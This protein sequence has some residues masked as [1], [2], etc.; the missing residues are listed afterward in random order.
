MIYINQV[1]VTANEYYDYKDW[2]KDRKD[3][4]PLVHVVS[5]RFPLTHHILAKAFAFLSK[6]IRNSESLRIL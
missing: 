6:D 4:N 2:H 1:N 5:V 3:P